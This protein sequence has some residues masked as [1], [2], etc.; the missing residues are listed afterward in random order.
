MAR[1][2]S[3]ADVTDRTN[4]VATFHTEFIN[5]SPIMLKH[6]AAFIETAQKFNGQVKP[7]KWNKAQIEVFL[8]SLKRNWNSN[9]WQI[10]IHGLSERGIR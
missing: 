6:Y 5:T 10:R 7:N 2:N 8:L 9:C 4:L 3:I 1:P